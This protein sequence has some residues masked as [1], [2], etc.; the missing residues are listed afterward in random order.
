MDYAQGALEHC[1]F[2]GPE[3]IID[4]PRVVARANALFDRGG[5]YGIA[6]RLRLA[7]ENHHG[8]SRVAEMLGA[9]VTQFDWSTR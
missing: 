2:S 8:N 1:V 9:A 4:P 5:A 3:D 6:A 7:L